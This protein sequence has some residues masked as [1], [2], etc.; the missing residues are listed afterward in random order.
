M[1]TSIR[2]VLITLPLVSLLA[3]VGGCY[4]KNPCSVGFF[5]NENGLC[6]AAPVPAEA[7]AAEAG[8]AEAGAAEAGA[9]E[10]GAP[11]ASTFGKACTAQA[12]CSGDA[13]VCAAPQLPYCTQISCQPGEAN[14][15]LCPAGFICVGGGAAG[16]ACMKK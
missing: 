16:S 7:G 1:K 13:P 8:A 15:G 6:E 2:T 14:A 9:S 12:D 5:E 11:A 3:L 10:G 4:L